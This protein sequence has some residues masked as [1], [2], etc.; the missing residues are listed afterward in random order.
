MI[1][2]IFTHPIIIIEFPTKGSPIVLSYHLSQL[3]EFLRDSIF[4]LETFLSKKKKKKKQQC[5]KLIITYRSWFIFEN[6]ENL[7]IGILNIHKGELKKN[8]NAT[9]LFIKF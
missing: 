5:Q 4:V 7:S 2:T 8:R 6:Y 9:Q 1:C 3:F